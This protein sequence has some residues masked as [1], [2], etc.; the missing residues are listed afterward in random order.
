MPIGLTAGGQVDGD[1]NLS[2][3]FNVRRQLGYPGPGGVVVDCAEKPG[4]VIR[5]S[6][7]ADLLHSVDIPLAFD[8]D[9]P[10][11]QPGFSAQ[12]TTKPPGPGYP[13]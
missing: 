1:G 12:S 2:A 10:L 9:V 5:I 11:P 8:P 4:C 6:S 3:T 13:S 7:Y